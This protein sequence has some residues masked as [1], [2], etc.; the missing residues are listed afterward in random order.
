MKILVVDDSKQ[1]CQAGLADLTA[2]GHEVIVLQDY[3]DV[4]MVV[5]QQS[6][7]VALI[8]LL[9]PAEAMTLGTKGLN[10]LG[11]AFAVGYPLAVY[12]ATEGI[13]VA[14][15]TDTNHHNH[16]A[17]AMMDWLVDKEVNINGHRVCF[18]R[19]PMKKI[20][21]TWVKDWPVALGQLI[22]TVNK[23]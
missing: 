23:S 2:L 9:M 11:E 8:D 3:S 17:S 13:Q 14:V 4:A 20:D 10:H 21:G 5:K 18:M 22:D 12:L 16:P 19:A 1:H 7:D 6:F 15:A